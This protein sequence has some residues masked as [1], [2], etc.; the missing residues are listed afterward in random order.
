MSEIESVI[1]IGSGPAGHTAAIYTARANLRP[2]M[3]EGFTAGGVAGGQL[4]ITTEVEN[5]PGFPE[6]ITG[7]ELMDRMRKQSERFG[8]RILTQD[9]QAVDLSQRPFRVTSDGKDYLARALIIATGA[10]ARYLGLP[11]EKRLMN[12]GVSACAT[13]DG[14]LPIFRN[15]ELVVVGGGDSAVEE[16]TYLTRFAGKVHLVHRR[17]KLRASKIMAER[18]RTHPKITLVLDTV[19]E[20]VLGKD[21]VSGVRLKNVKTGAVTELSVA[22][23]FLAIGHSPNTEIFKGQ[24]ALGESGYVETRGKSS[25]TSVDGVFACGDVQDHTYRQAISAAGSGCQAAIDTERWLEGQGG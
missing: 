12:R 25:Y 10:S 2:L 18:A 1:I 20:E 22:G 14:A 23:V 7:P 5:F 24:L 3:F 19:V 21:Q 16:A 9:V 17:D 15:K 8:T 11:S 4:M 13:C 6:G